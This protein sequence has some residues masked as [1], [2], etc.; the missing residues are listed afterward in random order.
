MHVFAKLKAKPDTA[1]TLTW[2]A[3]EEEHTATAP[4][5]TYQSTDTTARLVAGARVLA[6]NDE[7]EATELAIQYQLASKYTNLLLVHIAQ[8]KRKQMACLN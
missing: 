1:P 5:L 7:A 2:V 4:S 3:G 8:K 6:T